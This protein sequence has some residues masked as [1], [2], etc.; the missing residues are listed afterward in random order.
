[1]WNRNDAD[2]MKSLN[3]D[4]TIVCLDYYFPVLWYFRL[5][6]RR[7]SFY[8]RQLQCVSQWK[9]IVDFFLARAMLW[10]TLPFV[11]HKYS[12]C[13]QDLCLKNN[14][15]LKSIEI[16][17]NLERKTWWFCAYSKNSKKNRL[18]HFLNVM[19]LFIFF[20]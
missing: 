16:S 4:L 18:A 10:C 9:W 7:L 20:Y 19:F 2:Q 17:L 14:I 6:G 3:F 12:I 15:K 11:W 13:M 8:W 5:A 1:M